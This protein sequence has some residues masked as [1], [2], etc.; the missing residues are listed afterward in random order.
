MKI[1]QLPSGTMNQPWVQVAKYKKLQ[2]PTFY[3]SDIT[4]EVELCCY[5]GE[6]KEDKIMCCSENHFEIG[7]VFANKYEIYA[8]REINLVK[9]DRPLTAEE[10][11]EADYEEYFSRGDV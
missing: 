7:Y 9:G 11:Y 2:L 5:C 3:T 6:L 10:Q 4:D 8:E 1:L